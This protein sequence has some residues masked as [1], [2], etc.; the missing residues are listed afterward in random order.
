MGC[1]TLQEIEWLMDNL[2]ITQA[3]LSEM[4]GKSRQTVNAI[5]N[6]KYKVKKYHLLAMTYALEQFMQEHKVVYDYEA[7][8]L[9]ID[10]TMSCK[11]DTK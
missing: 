8:T 3:K 11:E 4:I 1:Y 9:F 7:K 10:F 5:F 2:G 6:G